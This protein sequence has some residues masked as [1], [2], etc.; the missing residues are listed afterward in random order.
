MKTRDVLFY[1]YR[2]SKL[3]GKFLK[4]KGE[5][6]NVGGGMNTKSGEFVAP[7]DDIYHF[8]FKCVKQENYTNNRTFYL[9][10]DEFKSGKT[11]FIS[12]T[13]MGNISNLPGS[14]TALVTL[15]SRDVLY[16]AN[17][18]S[19]QLFGSHFAR[20]TQFVGWLVQEELSLA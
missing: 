8:E 17:A 20:Y 6:L 18:G 7:V 2:T 14:M 19:G 1:V 12:A 4:F 10:I 5:E 9:K 13:H 15:K 3:L 11:R 16:L